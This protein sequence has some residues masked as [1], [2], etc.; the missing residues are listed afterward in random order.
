M[1]DAAKGN[2]CA[3]RKEQLLWQTR[4]T[5]GEPFGMILREF[6]GLAKTGLDGHG[7]YDVAGR[8]ADAQGITARRS[9]AFEGDAKLGPFMGDLDFRNGFFGRFAEKLQ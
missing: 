2:L 4:E 3:G 1:Q 5:L 9:D 8:R 6:L 7:Q